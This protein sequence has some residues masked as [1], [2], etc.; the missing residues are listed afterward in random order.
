[1][2]NLI[3]KSWAAPSRPLTKCLQA[4]RSPS[5]TIT[6]QSLHASYTFP[7]DQ[8]TPPHPCDNPSPTLPVLLFA[9]CLLLQDLLWLDVPATKHIYR[10]WTVIYH[11]IIDWNVSN[12]TPPATGKGTPAC[13]VAHRP[14]EKFIFRLS[15]PKSEGHPVLSELFDWQRFFY[16]SFY[17]S[18]A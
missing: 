11:R 13:S 6:T 16:H 2:I 7:Q 17:L 5:T 15:Q 12:W 1:M 8:K 14:P 3:I 18:N 4:T 10:Y 9:V